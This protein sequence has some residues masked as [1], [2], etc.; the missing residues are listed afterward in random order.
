MDPITASALAIKAIAEMVTEIVR[1]QPPEFRAKVYEWYV[2]DVEKIRRL[3]KLD[4]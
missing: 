1:G 4:A 2:A 3:L